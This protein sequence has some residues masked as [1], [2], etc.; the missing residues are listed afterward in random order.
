MKP[1]SEYFHECIEKEMLSLKLS[2]AEIAAKFRL[3]LYHWRNRAALKDPRAM[4]VKITLKN[5]V[6]TLIYS[7]ME[8]PDED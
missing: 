2:T 4:D 8:V 7:P 3:S 5:N 6:V 1:K